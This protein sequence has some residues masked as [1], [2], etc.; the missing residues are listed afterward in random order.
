MGTLQSRQTHWLAALIGLGLFLRLYHY[1]RC[2]SVW[3]DEA[4]LLVNVLGK[5]FREQLGPL[6]HAEAAPP[7]FLWMERAIALTL[8]DGIQ[9]MRLVPFV[10][11]CVALV[12]TAFVARRTLPAGL[13]LGAVLLVATSDRLL[14]HACEAKP[15]SIDVF[16]AIGLIALFVVTSRYSTV[17]QILCFL[18]LAPLVIWLSFPGCF[19]FG[20]VLLALLPRLIRSRDL[21]TWAAYAGLSLVVVGSFVGLYFGPIQA[22][23]CGTMDSCWVQTFPDWERWWTV[24][25]WAIATPF[26]VT[27]YLFAPIGRAIL[28]L[29]LLGAWEWWRSDRRELLVLVLAPVALVFVAASLHMYPAAGRVV[30]FTV[31]GL[32]LMSAVG[33]GVACDRFACSLPGVRRSLPLILVAPLILSVYRLVEPW[34]RADCQS[35]AEFVMASRQPGEVV[36]FNHWEYEYLFRR[37]AGP[38]CA[39]Q[40]E[41]LP[42]ADRLWL[43][44]TTPDPAD[45]EGLVIALQERWHIEQRQSFDLTEVVLLTPRFCDPIGSVGKIGST[46]TVIST[47][48]FGGMPLTEPGEMVSTPAN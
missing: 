14:W 30:A 45:R 16:C 17:T 48:F 37:E 5:T 7:L 10:L 4:A 35:A 6:F 28:P 18:P 34:P 15:Y 20:G 43:I 38:F 22:Q 21:A 24:P 44:F 41:P 25:L 46:R 2:P 33:L 26:E 40:G 12:L 39:W 3:H 36:A 11:G 27:R 23:R 19:L 42:T 1:L 8:G 31:P 13:A 32:A 47:D 29:V 9:A